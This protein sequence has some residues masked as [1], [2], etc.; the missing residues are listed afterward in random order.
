MTVTANPGQGKALVVMLGANIR[1][2][3]GEKQDS[4]RHLLNGSRA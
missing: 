2:C 1:R 4:G 3:R